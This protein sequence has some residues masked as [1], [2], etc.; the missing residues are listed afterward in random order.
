MTSAELAEIY[1]GYIAC[2]NG[3]DWARLGQY[4][5]D[6][7]Q[8]N[9]KRLGLS[10]YQ[11][12]LEGDHRAIPDLLFDIRLLVAEPPNVAARLY[13]DCTPKGDLFGIPVN[14][15]RVQFTEN[16]FYRFVDGRIETVWSIIDTDAIRAQVKG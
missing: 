9:G 14:G 10:G 13:F 11:T 5:G 1:R 8:H 7:A 15:R 12:M 16:V 2:L 4:V 3:Q 6:N